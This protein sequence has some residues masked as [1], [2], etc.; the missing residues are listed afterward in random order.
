MGERLE[1]QPWMVEPP[2]RAVLEALEA[3]GA[4]ARFVGGCVR[5]ALLSRA[6][7]DIDIATPERPERASELLHAAGIKVVPTGIEHGTVTAVLPQ[8]IFEVTSLRRDVETFGRH[9][10]VEYGADWAEDAAR[11]DFTMNALFLDA[12][13]AILDT[14]G[15]VADLR[16]GEV[17]F[18]GDA[19]Q[20][21]REDVLRLLRFYRFYAHYGRREA[22]AKA[23]AACRK[24]AQLLP[25]LSVERVATELQKLLAAPDPLPTLHMMQEDGV[26]REILPEAHG[27]ERL[28]RLTALEKRPDPIRRLAAL[29]GRDPA[30][31]HAIADRLKFSNAGRE[32]LSVLTSERVAPDAEARVQRRALYRLGRD[33]YVDLALLAA[34]D[35][36]LSPTPLLE[37][38]R[39]WEA[40]VFPLRGRDL[41]DAGIAPG[42]QLGR[43]LE[44][45]EEWWVDEDFVPDREACLAELKRR[46]AGREDESPR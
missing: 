22:D 16:A 5:D 17:R 1:P 35:A 28:A 26:L 23:R 44:N 11:R 38:A 3:G 14:V 25:T 20:R 24:L 12:G 43:L 42:P 36:G 41:V 15:G 18:V 31:A 34:A 7:A 10:R 21:I 4:P 9:A 39:E 13:G 8:R 2:T 29:I 33:D 37:V 27:L 30:A 19:E 46:F 40:P 32:R 6:I 45:L